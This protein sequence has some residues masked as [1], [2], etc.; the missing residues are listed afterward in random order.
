MVEIVALRLRQ[1]ELWI[2]R[3]LRGP[4]ASI[5]AAFVAEGLNRPIRVQSEDWSARRVGIVLEPIDAAL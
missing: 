3:S 2:C 1:R 5:V 4:L